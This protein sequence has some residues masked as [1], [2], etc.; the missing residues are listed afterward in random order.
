VSAVKNTGVGLVLAGGGA[1]GAYE[2]GALSVLLP[3]LECQ[4]ERPS[5][6]IGTSV[7]AINAAFL[8]SAH[9][10]RAEESGAGLVARWREVRK[11]RVV[12]PIL[13]RQVPLTAFRY[14]G[15]ILSLPGV[16]L[17]SLLDPAPLEGSLER[18]IDWGALRRNVD[19]RRLDAITVV[20]TAARSGRSVGFCDGCFERQ[21]HRSHV[22]DYV[23][24]EL[25]AEHVRAS[26]SIPILFPP[27]RVERPGEARG[28]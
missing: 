13:T 3:A 8:A 23:R 22:I 17:R 16:R 18:W 7:G 25:T 15:E 10:S 5:I 24:G 14:A 4:G 26:A 28:W 27:V 19:E 9:D 21:L 11:G 12:R 20:A 2:A 6:L 1:R